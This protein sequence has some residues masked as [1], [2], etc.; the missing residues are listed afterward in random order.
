MKSKVPI[1]DTDHASV[2]NPFKMQ[3][4]AYRSNT[5][6]QQVHGLYNEQKFR[7]KPSFLNYTRSDFNIIRPTQSNVLKAKNLSV[8]MNTKTAVEFMRAGKCH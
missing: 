2:I 1:T 7:S 4:K 5:Q 8:S 6:S 3:K